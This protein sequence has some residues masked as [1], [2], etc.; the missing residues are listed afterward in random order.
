MKTLPL[1]L[2]LLAVGLS[3]AEEKKPCIFCEIVAGQRE[4]CVI[5]RDPEVIAFLS[6]GPQNPGHVLVVPIQ[7]AD[8]ILDLPPATARALI[9]VAQKVAQAIKLTDL[10]LIYGAA[11][12]RDKFEDL[13]VHLIRSERPAPML[14]HALAGLGVSKRRADGV[15]CWGLD[16]RYQTGAPDGFTAPC[17]RNFSGPCAWRRWAGVSPRRLTRP[18]R[19]V[20]ADHR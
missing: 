3:S 6:I 17:G 2:L 13:A 14:L 10:Q 11:G 16:D 18:G 9:T 20:P 19:L 15:L 1:L 7:H 12:A 8:G 4:N 5:Y